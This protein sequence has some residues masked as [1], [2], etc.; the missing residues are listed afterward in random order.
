MT[1]TQ[2]LAQRIAG[3]KNLAAGRLVGRAAGTQVKADYAEPTY[4]D[5]GCDVGPSCLNC[6]LSACKHDDE[7]PYRVWAKAAGVTPNLSA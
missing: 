7:G 4:T 1:T 5:T 3:L 6:P 2:T